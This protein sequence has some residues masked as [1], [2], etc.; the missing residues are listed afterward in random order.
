MS[1]EVNSPHAMELQAQA[2]TPED[3]AHNGHF[4]AALLEAAK[5]EPKLRTIK[6]SFFVWKVHEVDVVGE[7][8]HVTFNMYASWLEEISNIQ[9][10]PDGTKDRWTSDMFKWNPQL[11]FGNRLEKNPDEY[12]SWW[13][14]M[15]DN[16]NGENTD[17]SP[18][19][20]SE[21]AQQKKDTRVNITYCQRFQCWFSESFELK[22]FP[23]D[24][25]HL[26]IG[27]TSAWDFC[28][29]VLTFDQKRATKISSKAIDESSWDMVAPRLLAF[30]VDWIRNGEQLLSFSGDSATGARYCRA[31]LALTIIRK[32][33][34]TL[35]N[36]L[37]MVFLIGFS[38]FCVFA[39]EPTE[40]GDRQSVVLTLILTTV[41]FIL[42][43]RV[44]FQRSRTSQ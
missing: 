2:K 34:F 41:A 35:W 21:L 6:L 20:L 19:K 15:S 39:L 27:V 28:N 36:V 22:D 5:S 16:E 42:S 26:H 24:L 10:E 18:S 1:A 29:V 31:Y 33:Q 13:R 25:Q 40:L 8:F 7:R 17:V 14:V 11:R 9:F 37:T 4:A 38:S 43:P 32:P 30:D 3:K 44:C 23:F 12:E